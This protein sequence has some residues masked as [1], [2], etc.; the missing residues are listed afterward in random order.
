MHYYLPPRQ[1]PTSTHYLSPRQGPS[2]V[3]HVRKSWSPVVALAWPG[4]GNGYLSPLLPLPANN[5]QGFPS[6]GGHTCP[7]DRIQGPQPRPTPLPPLRETRHLA[8][9][10]FASP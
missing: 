2:L 8:I 5:R 3:A 7:P 1:G 10:S 9:L 6:T 4:H